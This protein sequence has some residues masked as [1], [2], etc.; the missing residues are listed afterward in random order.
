MTATNS[1]SKD[2]SYR[3]TEKIRVN[4][5]L[6]VLI[7]SLEQTQCKTNV[8]F[9]RK[10]KR[11][12]HRPLQG[13]FRPIPTESR[14][15]VCNIMF[16]RDTI[17]QQRVTALKYLFFIKRKRKEKKRAHSSTES[18]PSTSPSRRRPFLPCSCFQHLPIQW[19][20]LLVTLLLWP[21]TR[22]PGP[23]VEKKP[24]LALPP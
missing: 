23:Q 14:R 4:D 18:V 5:D 15:F 11:G 7:Q 22:P 17:D 8:Q 12:Q 16:V 10:E 9:K 13:R 24:L 19:S 21:S 2:S 20:L 1:G 6:F 3:G